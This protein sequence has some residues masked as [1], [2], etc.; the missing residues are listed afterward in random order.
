MDRECRDLLGQIL[1]RQAW[2]ME[3]LGCLAAQINGEECGPELTRLLGR[4]GTPAKVVDLQARRHER[5]PDDD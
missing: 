3:L 5:G 1:A 4:P 2:M